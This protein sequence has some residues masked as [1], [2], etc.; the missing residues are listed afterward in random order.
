MSFISR[1]TIVVCLVVAS[2]VLVSA[3]SSF[4]VNTTID[5]VDANPGDG[6]CADVNG[7]CSLRAAIMEANANADYTEVILGA[8][9]Y[10]TTLT[11]GPTDESFGDLDINQST[12][13]SGAGADATFI[14]NGIAGERVMELSQGAN[15][16]W[17]RIENLTLRDGHTSAEGG[18]LYIAS[19]A[20]VE[21]KN[22]EVADNRAS[23]GGGIWIESM[24]KSLVLADS[25]I[26]NNTATDSCGGLHVG[27]TDNDV[28]QNITFYGNTAVAGNGGAVCFSPYAAQPSHRIPFLNF[29]TIAQNSAGTSGGGIMSYNADRIWLTNSIV[30]GNSAGASGANCAHG[31]PTQPA[32]FNDLGNIFDLQGC[33]G[34]GESDL[35][36]DA[37]V[38]G[39]L[40]R[41]T[42]GHTRMF[43]LVYGSPALDFAFDPEYC[44]YDAKHDQRSVVRPQGPSCDAGAYEMEQGP[45]QTYTVNSE[46]DTVDVALGDAICADASGNCSLRAAIMQA[47]AF[48][49][50]DTIIIPAGHYIS[51][52]TSG[53]TDDSYGDFDILHPVTIQGVNAD[54]TVISSGVSGERVLE[55]KVIRHPNQDQWDSTGSVHIERASFTGGNTAENGGGILIDSDIMIFMPDTEV[56]GNTASNGGGIWIE[57]AHTLQIARSTIA[58]NVATDSCGGIY[59]GELG[60]LFDATTTTV[61]HNQAIAGEGGGICFSEG[62]SE[63]STVMVIMSTIVNNSAGTIGGGILNRN[64]QDTELHEIPNY[65]VHHSLFSGNMAGISGQNCAFSGAA[66]IAVNSG[67]NLFDAN[68]CI[69][70]SETDI[71]TNTPGVGTLALHAPGH[72]RSVNLLPDSAA[73]DAGDIFYTGVTV[74]Q[75]GVHRPSGY[76]SDIGAYEL[77]QPGVW[78]QVP[79]LPPLPEYFLS[80]L[81]RVEQRHSSSYILAANRRGQLSIRSRMLAVI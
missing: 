27:S 6:V 66:T 33:S 54:Q 20:I 29:V 16:A 39:T 47:N 59:A 75:R 19:E 21:L 70:A 68:G 15:V 67:L 74:D 43:D 14:S 8:G 44:N 46:A 55:I 2:F 36:T 45:A 3:Q 52:L 73:V 48:G 17:G 23:N 28:I 56:S 72:T 60:W 53:P 32:I 26:I 30:V 10:V 63:T 9:D 1:F 80:K 51:S 40:S 13:I 5:S 78:V 38:L 50:S 79:G 81:V 31:T 62:T 41:H 4:T 65:F 34:A 58:E 64:T 49:N 69:N 35:V 18:G 71:I 22:I 42:P 77:V 76:S 61:A 24:T 25:S 57:N 37:P 7:L 12:R 11:S